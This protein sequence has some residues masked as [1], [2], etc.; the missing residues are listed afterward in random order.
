MGNIGVTI[1]TIFSIT[2]FAIFRLRFYD[3]SDYDVY[4]FEFVFALKWLKF[5]IIATIPYQ[6]RLVSPGLAAAVFYFFC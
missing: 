2:I 1:F 3:F 6:C 4:D 5:D